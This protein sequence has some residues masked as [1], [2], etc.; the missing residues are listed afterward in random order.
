MDT[1]AH[2]SDMSLTEGVMG[3]AFEAANVR[4]APPPY[5]FARSS[6]STLPPEITTPTDWISGGSL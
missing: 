3:S 2:G 1:D 5:I 4:S 6:K